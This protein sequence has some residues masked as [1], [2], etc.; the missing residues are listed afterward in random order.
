LRWSTSG[1]GAG[2][3]TGA[4]PTTPTPTTHTSTENMLSPGLPPRPISLT[5]TI[6]GFFLCLPQRGCP[7]HEHP[8]EGSRVVRVAEAGAVIFAHNVAEFPLS[9]WVQI[10]DGWVCQ[11]SSAHGGE[12]FWNTFLAVYSAPSS[13]TTDPTVRP[14]GYKSPQRSRDGS[15]SGSGNV[16]LG[17][18]GEIVIRD[19]MVAAERAARAPAVLDGTEPYFGS[20]RDSSSVHMERMKSAALDSGS[21]SISG[22]G[23][24]SGKTAG[25]DSPPQHIGLRASPFRMPEGAD[26]QDQAKSRLLADISHVTS[27]MES[28]ALNTTMLDSQLLSVADRLQFLKGQTESL[29]GSSND[30]DSDGDDANREILGNYDQM[31]DDFVAATAALATLREKVSSMMEK[32]SNGMVKIETTPPKQR[33][34]P[35]TNPS[36]SSPSSSMAFDRGQGQESPMHPITMTPFGDATPT[37]KHFL[38]CVDDFDADTGV[39]PRVD[40]VSSPIGVPLIP[41][42]ETE[43]QRKK[44]ELREHRARFF[45]DLSSKK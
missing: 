10:P 29:Y 19:L 38:D 5:L 11:T 35:S 43:D 13:A 36:L 40:R 7:V 39:S 41:E 3:G 42:N 23:S 34:K 9:K 28:L 27:H 12:D 26:E 32:A 4:T 44:R 14:G 25:F 1:S 24:G 30:V 31:S 15:G 33:V 20:V 17:L 6:P 2:T 21:D 18:P 22:S 37:R 16:N 8:V 45:T